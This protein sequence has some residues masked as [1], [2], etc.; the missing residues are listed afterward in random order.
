[1]NELNGE[2]IDIR[3]NKDFSKLKMFSYQIDL[4]LNLARKNYQPLK[5]RF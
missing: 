3:S 4:N 5:V 1:M 2:I